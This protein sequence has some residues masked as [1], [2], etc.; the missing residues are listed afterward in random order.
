MRSENVKHASTSALLVA[1]FAAVTLALAQQPP[2]AEPTA[3]PPPS[4]AAEPTAEPPPSTAAETPTPTPPTT[5]E[6]PAPAGEDDAPTATTGPEPAP[7]KPAA[8]RGSPQRFEPSEKVRAD[9]D[10]AFPIDI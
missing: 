1:G 3:E 8:A 5:A 2:A 6:A 9:F 10:V 4:T 7:N